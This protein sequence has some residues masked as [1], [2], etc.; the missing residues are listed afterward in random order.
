LFPFRER[1]RK[2]V[3]RRKERERTTT[4]EEGDSL[5]SKSDEGLYEVV[6]AY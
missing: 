4:G 5:S 3:R 6:I 1:K 2:R